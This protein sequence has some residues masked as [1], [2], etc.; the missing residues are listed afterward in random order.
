MLK[1]AHKDDIESKPDSRHLTRISRNAGLI[2]ALM[3]VT[4]AFVWSWEGALSILI[5][6]V[7][8]LLN[9]RWMAGAVDQILSVGNIAGEQIRVGRFLV[10]YLGRLILILVGLFAIIKLSFLSLLGALMGLSVFVLAG[11]LEAILLMLRRQGTS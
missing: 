1:V 6:G 11:F 3:T 8:A 9:F 7:L 4:A 5:G 2:M 10:S